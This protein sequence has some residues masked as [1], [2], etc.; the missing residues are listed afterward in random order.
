MN[1]KDSKKTEG[2]KYRLIDHEADI[3]LEVY[4]KT[5][6]ELFSNAACG[7]FQ[8]IVDAEK[9]EAEKGKR[10]EIEANGEL[11][12]NFLNELIYLWD[13]EGFIPKEFSLKIDGR[14]VYGTVA[15][16]VFDPETCTMKQEVKAVTYH[17]FFL[18][19]ENGI[20]TAQ[21]ILDV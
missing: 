17:K 18:K 2:I 7:V 20:Y 3:G 21:F 15:G 5:M 8:F 10:I 14:R 4:G 19:E 6:E 1:K 16:A 9:K 13:T 11:L 12:I